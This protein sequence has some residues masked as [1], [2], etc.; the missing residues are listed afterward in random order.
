MGKPWSKSCNLW[1]GW[2]TRLVEPGRFM[3]KAA[4]VPVDCTAGCIGEAPSESCA[5]RSPVL[6]NEIAGRAISVE[7]IDIVSDLACGKMAPSVT[8]MSLRS[9]SSSE[10]SMT[11]RRSAMCAENNGEWTEDYQEAGP[12]APPVPSAQHKA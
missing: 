10:K 12:S 7:G 9:S 4:P 5:S 8:T 2:L 11:A 6:P 3:I 1:S